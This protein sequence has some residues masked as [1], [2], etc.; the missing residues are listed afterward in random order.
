MKRLVYAQIRKSNKNVNVMCDVGHFNK[1]KKNRSK[2]MIDIISQI[3]VLIIVVCVFV[4]LMIM[5]G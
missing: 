2:S 3:S 4:W 1:I 5:M